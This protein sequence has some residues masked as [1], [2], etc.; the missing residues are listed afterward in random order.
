MSAL[1]C[2]FWRRLSTVLLILCW[3]KC[4]PSLG[5]QLWNTWKRTQEKAPGG[6]RCPCP[7]QGMYSV[8][9]SRF[10]QPNPLRDSLLTSPFLWH[11][12][13]RRCHTVLRISPVIKQRW[14]SDFGHSS[15]RPHGS[16]AQFSLPDLHWAQIPFYTAQ[17]NPRMSQKMLSG[18]YVQELP[19]PQGWEFYQLHTHH[20]SCN[21]KQKVSLQR[22]LG[23]F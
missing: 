1:K 14:W 6:R 11:T 5:K 19:I 13:L 18:P 21:W 2:F 9:F 7:L 10:L 23:F 3:V 17:L 16:A 22:F 8:T 20:K 12:P 4:H 15:H